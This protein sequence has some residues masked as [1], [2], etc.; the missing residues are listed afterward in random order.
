VTVPPAL[1]AAG[2][3][4]L[5]AATASA[6]DGL[7]AA[8]ARPR[9]SSLA[10]V[11]LALAAGPHLDGPALLATAL[12]ATG[13]GVVLAPR[14]R[15]AGGLVGAALLLAGGAAGGARAAG[16]EDTR[17]TP[18]LGH[19]MREH[20][21]VHDAPRPDAY[22]GWSAVVRLRGEP[23]L[24][25][26]RDRRPAVAVGDGLHV[27][28][29]LKPP[30][31]WAS[32]LRMHAELRASS[33][34]PSGHRR[35]GL[36]GALDTVRRRAQD[37]LDQEL[38]PAQAGLLRGMVLGDD[39]AL[40][41]HV[42]D[43]F[44][45]SG[46]AHLVAASGTNVMLL[47]TLAIALAMAAG[48]ERVGRLAF[49]LVLIALYVP[50]AG[51]GPS[52][53][54]AGI[55]GGAILVAALAGRPASRW[56]ALGLA[57]VGTL[58][59]DPRAVTALGWQLSFVAV[60]GILLLAPRWRETLR[61][62]GTPGALADA[63]AVTGAA[64]LATAPVLAA[65]LGEVSPVSL[66]ANVLAAPAVAPIM[67]L[68]FLAAAVGQ[69]SAAPAAVL[70]AV[71]GLPLGY[72]TWLAGAAAGLPWAVV[73]A[74]PLAVTGVCAAVVAVL[75]S[76]RV[77][78]AAPAL[79]V[80]LVVV[81]VVAGAFT[82]SHRAMPPGPPA[83]LRVT[84]LDVGQGDAVLLQE[85]GRAVLVDTGPP[86]GEVIDRLREA[87]VRRLDALVVTHASSDHE[88]GAAAVLREL[89]VGLLID[90]R[91][92][93]G[94]EPD[95]ASL[96]PLAGAD[97]ARVGGQPDQGAAAGDPIAAAAREAGVRRIEPSAGQTLRAGG[98]ALRV[99][100]PPPVPAGVQAPLVGDHNE[101]ATVLELEAW[102]ARVLL[103]A[104][105]ESDVLGRLDLAP[106]DVLK[107]PHHGS[108]DAGLPAILARVAPRVAV[109]PVG[110]G[111]PYGHPAPSTLRTLD[112]VPAVLRTDH[113][114][115]I[116]LDLHGGRWLV[117]T[118]RAP[119]GG[120]GG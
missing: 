69:V 27:R 93:S 84:V 30:G 62:R 116:R 109:I 110:R 35:D 66:G 42:R 14:A 20:V 38:P 32:R 78:R 24:L 94:R 65:T 108:A 9:H 101:R 26:A 4:W 71:A 43:D 57:A 92:V 113:H 53:Q 23:V 79:A 82:R 107:V 115:T 10:L 104:D 33:V 39:S 117:R 75:S 72:L 58:V 54:R 8:R 70:D 74:G 47:A 63:V 45:A 15:L 49:A 28:G 106:V 118:T 64:G 68:G 1:L 100:W 48:L 22:G 91:R 67:W 103:P 95:E 97:P 25:L 77:R 31:V 16:L 119:D 86:D 88:G 3:A 73:P 102:G 112:A 36:P 46:L 29:V 87:E 17:L 12:L 90:G 111:N 52:I 99:R 18:A 59:L 21:V 41:P 98:L 19:A 61:R 105:A 89:D 96:G 37:A 34:T 60:V 44:R 83:G 6:A 76:R 56:Y 120:R 55:M 13:L 2:R 85:P 51:G 114:G 81:A 5:A 80:V 7:E 11:V 40:P 50:L